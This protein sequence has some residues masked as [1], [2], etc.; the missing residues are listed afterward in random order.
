MGLHV[1]FSVRHL[2]YRLLNLCSDKIFIFLTVQ[3]SRRMN[4]LEKRVFI[5]SH[6]LER[7]SALDFKDAA[8]PRFG[9]GDVA[10]VYFSNEQQKLKSVRHLAYRLLNL[11]SDKIFI[12]LTV[13]ESRRMNHL[14]KTVF[15]TSHYLERASALDSK[16]AAA[17][18]FGHGD[19]A[20]VYF[21]N[22]QQKLPPVNH[23][24]KCLINRICGTF[25]IKPNYFDP[26]VPKKAKKVLK[27][28][29]RG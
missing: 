28:W 3:E 8:A 29:I 19:V 12:F 4:H 2:A 23:Q 1:S 21:S 17:P 22:E 20:F 13:Q 25:D 6:Y 11:C 18:R 15:I 10:F 16:D 14:E 7:A 27:N 26:V 9:H 5:T 24:R